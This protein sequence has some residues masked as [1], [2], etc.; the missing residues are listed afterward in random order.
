MSLVIGKP[1]YVEPSMMGHILVNDNLTPRSHING[2]APA[3][4]PSQ[5]QALD[6]PVLA[7]RPIQIGDRG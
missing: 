7:W 6:L 4:Q 5:R 2:L 3:P 1:C